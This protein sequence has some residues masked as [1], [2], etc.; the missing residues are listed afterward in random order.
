[1]FVA[2]LRSAR[3]ETG[4]ESLEVRLVAWDEIPWDHLAFPSVTG[5][6]R[7]FEK[8]RGQ[9]VFTPFVGLLGDR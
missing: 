6:L 1:M 8:V 3:I 2:R 9:A 5:A 4:E 7:H